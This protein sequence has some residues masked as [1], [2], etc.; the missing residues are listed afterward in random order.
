M[1]IVD[2]SD[3]ENRNLNPNGQIFQY[4]VVITFNPRFLIN[5]TRIDVKISFDNCVFEKGFCI[6]L[7][8]RSSEIKTVEI[9]FVSCYSKKGSA[10]GLI[11]KDESQEV[12][13]T[14]ISSVLT[15]FEIQ[16]SAFRS[17]H[18]SRVVCFP[19]RFLARESNI[20]LISF[21]NCVGRYFVND[22]GNSRVSIA[23]N[24][25]NLYVDSRN[26]RRVY[27][28][29][30][31]QQGIGKIFFLKTAFYLADVGEVDVRFD[32]NR[33]DA[34]FKRE[35][36]PGL[37]ANRRQI[38]YSPTDQDIANLDISL[39]IDQSRSL[40]KK[41]QISNAQL[42]V[43]AVTGAAES[44]INIEH[45]RAE[46]IYINRFKAKEFQFYDIRSRNNGES[47]FEM[48]NSHFGNSQFNKVY[49]NS[50][51]IVNCYRSY[52]EEI[53]FSGSKFPRAFESVKN[54]HYPDSKE[55]DYSEMQ[56][57]LYRQLKG[58]LVKSS[59]QVQALDMHTRMFNAIHKSKQLGAE[60]KF[61]LWTNK[62]SNLHETSCFR[63]FLVAVII[64]VFFWLL[65]CLYLPDKP[66]V[67]GWN[68]WTEFFRAMAVFAAFALDNAKVL[69]VLAN[70]V[71]SINNL[72]DL[73]D[74]DTGAKLTMGNYTVSFAS[75]ILVAW[76]YYQFVSAFRKFGKKL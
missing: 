24:D 69:L 46:N 72:S 11:Q 26:I 65:Y 76:A 22:M 59:N 43:L 44:A 37:G 7:D 56:Y 19:G 8:I 20:G 30:A 2:I 74:Q 27:K 28:G 9:T 50:F 58:A 54:I 66:V 23:Y 64:V 17:I 14:C 45:L 15:D 18:F 41:A 68:G 70:P 29:L 60:D 71:H 31:G 16:H 49:F 10:L 42:S 25:N 39:S 40:T 4:P 12:E 34:G 53:R 51:N 36:F 35:D 61:V 32:L 67:V 13:L 33:R 55:D 48:V 1:I 62:M 73:L 38:R 3:P 57:E 21:D 5:S 63:A 6:E 75:R 52:M 47:K